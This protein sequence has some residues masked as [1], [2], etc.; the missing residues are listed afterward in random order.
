LIAAPKRP[1]LSTG[2]GLTNI[3]ERLA[4]TYGP[5]HRFAIRALP[6]QGFAVEIEIPYQLEESAREAA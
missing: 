4:Q 5:D 3:R 6:N 2:V 1:T